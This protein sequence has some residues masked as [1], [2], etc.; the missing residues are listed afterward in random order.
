MAAI[1]QGICGKCGYASESV[2]DHSVAVLI[3]LDR[4]SRLTGLSLRCVSDDTGEL[5]AVENLRLL[6]LPHPIEE[7]ILT[8]AGLTLEEVSKQ[9][10]FVSVTPVVCRRCGTVFDARRLIAASGLSGCIVGAVIAF[11]VL[12]GLS[13]S[14]GRLELALPAASAVLM[15]FVAIWEFFERWGLRRYRTRAAALARPATCPNCK[16]PSIQRV[17][18]SRPVTCPSCGQRS[19]KFK[20]V[21]IS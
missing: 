12:V 5:A 13:W 18:K 20:M 16:S 4:A 1:C 19:M 21:G 10:R 2:P 17:K 7:S 3:D 11:G 8:S 14:T 15:S 6:H 9:G